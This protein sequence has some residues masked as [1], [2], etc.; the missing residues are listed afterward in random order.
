MASALIIFDHAWGKLVDVVFNNL[1]LGDGVTLGF[2][3]IAEMVTGI[4]LAHITP[5]ATTRTYIHD[6]IN[7][8]RS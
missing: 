6:I 5:I 8:K 3:F 2:I 1:V 4:L 7:R